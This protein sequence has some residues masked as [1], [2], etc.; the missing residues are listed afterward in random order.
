MG[1]A[2]LSEVDDADLL[3]ALASEP[4]SLEE[5]YRRHV[6]PLTR[7][8][9]RRV[10]DGQIADDVVATTF[11]AT[12]ESAHGYDPARGRPGAWLFGIAS[13]VMAA[14]ARRMAVESRA[15]ARLSGQSTVTPDDFARVDERVDARRRSGPASAVLAALPAA[16]RD[17]LDLLLHAELTV[18][19]AAVK[20]G[21]R[22]G[23]ARM[24]LA[25]ARGRLSLLLSESGHD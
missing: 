21:I 25:R 20:L 18:S 14:E 17:L 8:V 2:D 23:T 13:N 15:M 3:A 24:R 7:Y 16:E 4:Q 1:R 5:F 6:R 9:R 22:S 11:L 12:I 19:E 10:P